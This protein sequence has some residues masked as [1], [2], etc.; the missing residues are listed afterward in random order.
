MQ[1]HIQCTADEIHAIK[2]K[3]QIKMKKHAL[4]KFNSQTISE[5]GYPGEHRSMTLIK[6]V[7]DSDLRWYV[8]FHLLTAKLWLHVMVV[9]AGLGT[10]GWVLAAM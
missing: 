8:V 3:I 5:S 9:T 1:K 2:K 4:I 6:Q 7:K 10:A